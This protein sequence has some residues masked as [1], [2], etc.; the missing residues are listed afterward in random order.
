M[1][2]ILFVTAPYHAGVVEVAGRWVPLYM[3]ALAGAC[4]AAGHECRIYDAM[5]KEAGLAAIGAVIKEYAPD[6]VAVSMITATAVDSLRVAALAKK[7][8]PGVIT[9]AGGIHASFMDAEVLAGGDVDYVVIGEGEETLPELL[10]V[11]DAGRDP[12]S[13][14]GISFTAANGRVTRTPPRPLLACLD[15]RPMAWDLLDWDDYT[16]YIL[17]GSRLGAVATSRG[18]RHGCRFCSQHVFWR[19]SWR[20]RSPDDV[21]AEVEHLHR[22]YGVDVVLF[23]D[24]YPT[25]DQERWRGILHRLAGSGLGVRL[26]METRAADIIRDRSL[27]PLYRRAGIIHIYIGTE[28]TCQADLDRLGKEQSVDES[29]L[30]IDLC[31]E[32][33][34]ITETSMIIGFPGDTIDAIDRVIDQAIDLNPDFVHFLAIAPWPYADMA[35]EL[36][37]FVAVRDYRRYN[38]VDPV[39]KPTSMTLEEVDRAIIEGYRRFYMH[40]FSEITALED[41]FTRSYMLTAMRRMMRHSFIRKKLASLYREMP[42]GLRAMLEGA[43]AAPG[44]TEPGAGNGEE[45][46]NEVFHQ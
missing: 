30:A 42:P 34:I 38:L 16:Y 14:A 24:D 17:P 19:G 28:S 31:R 15:N 7:C 36:E 13:V 29:R 18:C 11:L 9:I 46:Q 41:G 23:T 43:S 32:H 5:T 1:K 35:A 37:P 8:D 40:K 45:G 12:S 4:R 33:G 6:V 22:R 26:L 20:G 21:V 44:V 3:V 2:K 27:L 39:V 10:A 25:P